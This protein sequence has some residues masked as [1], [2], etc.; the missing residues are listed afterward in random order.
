MLTGL[1]ERNDEALPCCVVWDLTPEFA[2]STSRKHV[3]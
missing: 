2:A 1:Y 3:G